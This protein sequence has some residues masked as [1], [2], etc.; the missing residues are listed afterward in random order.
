MDTLRWSAIK[1][2]LTIGPCAARHNCRGRGRYASSCRHACYWARTEGIDADGY[3]L[4]VNC[5]DHG[6][7]EVYH[8]HMHL[9]GGRKL[10]AMLARAQ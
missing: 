6:A 7:Q 10:G 8:L 2:R 9:L 3:R 1:Q 5:R 4:I